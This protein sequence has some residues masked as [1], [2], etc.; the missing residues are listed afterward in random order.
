MASS[1]VN[2]VWLKMFLLIA[3]FGTSSVYGEI[4]VAT[5]SVQGVLQVG[6]KFNPGEEPQHGSRGI[7]SSF[8]QVYYLQLPAT[9]GKQLQAQGVQIEKPEA[10]EVYSK[11]VDIGWPSNDRTYNPFDLNK[12]VGLKLRVTGE[13][14]SPD[15]VFSQ[16]LSPVFM[17]AIKVEVVDKFEPHN[18]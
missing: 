17:K 18:W 16:Y 15:R 12:K 6:E 5:C 1:K 14:Y 3:L 13:L 10:S 11:M 7:S 4:W 8:S 2:N 9:L